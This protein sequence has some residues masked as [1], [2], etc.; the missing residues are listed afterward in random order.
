MESVQFS[1]RLQRLRPRFCLDWISHRDSTTHHAPGRSPCISPCSRVP[2]LDLRLRSNPST[3]RSCHRDASSTSAPRKAVTAFH[4]P[5]SRPFL[6]SNHPRI[7]PVVH[8]ENVSCPTSRPV[9]LASNP[10]LWHFGRFH[11]ESDRY[12]ELNNGLHTSIEPGIR[13]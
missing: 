7:V 9:D 12:R 1:R 5:N 6:H 4:Y 3:S 11:T 8:A 2:L 13:G 10:V